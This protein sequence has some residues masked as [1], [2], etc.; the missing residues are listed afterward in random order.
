MKVY[1]IFIFLMIVQ[2]MIPFK[3][4]SNLNEEI[5]CIYNQ[6]DRI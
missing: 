6:E 4:L 2:E 3:I 5:K 1:V